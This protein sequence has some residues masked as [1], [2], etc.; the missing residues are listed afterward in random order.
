M[1][2]RCL[3]VSCGDAREEVD[4]QARR[5]GEPAIPKRARRS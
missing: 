3:C 2:L 4:L 5:S 1:S